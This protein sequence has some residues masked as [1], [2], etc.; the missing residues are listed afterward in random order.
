MNNKKFIPL[1][2]D[3]NGNKKINYKCTRCSKII[4]ILVKQMRKGKTKCS[5]DKNNEYLEKLKYKNIKVV[6]LQ[7]YKNNSTKILHKCICGVEW[8]VRPSHVLNGTKCNECKNSKTSKRSK[9]NNNDYIKLLKEKNIKVKP[10]EEY[11]GSKEKI[12]HKCTCGNIWEVIPN[13]IL[14][15][16]K[17]GCTKGGLSSEETYKGRK[18]LLYF[19]NVDNKCYKV[20]ICLFKMT[21]E[22]SIKARF[23]NDIKKG[24]N[25]EIIKTKI[26]AD[27]SKAYITEQQLLNKYKKYKYNKK[28]LI[29]GNTELLTENI[30]G[31]IK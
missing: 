30:Q 21:V 26:Y 10:L 27:G 23:S 13:S 31:E 22:K 24:I 1:E 5:C 19:I 20:G 17:C 25:I 8:K 14:M 4:N 2:D 11:K 12:K 28:I 7:E 29:S 16:Q 9:F 18:T 15:G 3:S 6:P